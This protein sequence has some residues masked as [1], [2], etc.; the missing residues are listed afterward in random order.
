MIFAIVTHVRTRQAQTVQHCYAPF[1]DQLV[2][3]YMRKVYL[4]YRETF[5]KSTTF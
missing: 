2:H 3:L 1:N 4:E 5:D